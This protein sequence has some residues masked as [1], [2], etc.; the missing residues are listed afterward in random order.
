M[1]FDDINKPP[2]DPPSGE[3]RLRRRSS[4]SADAADG[5]V[6]R[7]RRR[8]GSERSTFR[9]AARLDQA[10]PRSGGRSHLTWL[11]V[12][13]LLIAAV[14]GFALFL[15]KEKTA[16][17]R[18]SGEA[19]STLLLPC[20][21]PL[22]APLEMGP[23]GCDP[24]SLAVLQEMFREQRRQLNRDDGE[25]YAVAGTIA[26]ILEE[27]AVDR[28]RHLERLARLGS[29]GV[30]L[31]PDPL[32]RPDLS[33]NERRHFEMAVTVSWQRNSGSYRNRLEELWLRLLGLER[34]RFS[35]GSAPAHMVGDLP[36]PYTPHDD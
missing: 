15:Q 33:E 2:A 20:I 29:R 34:G 24:A 19:P 18:L 13:G 32:A 5:P 17:T 36:P 22:L 21:D 12:L 30:G 10:A 23:A 27:S 31:T 8:R 28:E 26:Q 25:I 14:A 7:R 1:I 6:R 11:W 4:S 9:E 16:P 3:G 35:S